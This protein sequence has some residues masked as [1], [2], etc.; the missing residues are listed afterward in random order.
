MA[1]CTVAA[2]A[3]QPVSRR[4][5]PALDDALD[6]ARRSRTGANVPRMRTEAISYDVRG[7]T[8]IGYLALPDGDGPRAGVLIAHEGTGLGPQVKERAHQLAQLGYVAFAVDYIGGGEVLTELTAMS[9]RLAELRETDVVRE[10]AR[11]GLAILAGRPEVDPTR[12]AAI[13]YCFGGAFVLELARSGADV[14]C[15]VGFHASL[16]TRDPDAARNITGKILACTGA[17]DPL[18]GADERAAFEQE[19]RAARVDWRHEIYG[20]AVHGF[21]NPLADRLGNP[22]VKYHEP[23][24][25]RSW[26]SMLALFEETIGGPSPAR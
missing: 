8:Y 11:A 25:R 1:R 13:G 24:H 14:A 4:A 26:R 9:A 18:V 22:A 15:T 3:G 17:D 12:I 19:M 6:A 21:A 2:A 10:L 20:N 5:P 23:S 16:K 7:V